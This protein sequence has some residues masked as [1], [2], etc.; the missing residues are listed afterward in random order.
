METPRRIRIDLLSP[1]EMAIYN[2]TL[3]VEKAGAD[4]RLTMA[5]IKLQ[6]ARALVADFIDDVNPITDEPNQ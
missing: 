3:E 5:T 6:Q 1:A 4:R 2:A